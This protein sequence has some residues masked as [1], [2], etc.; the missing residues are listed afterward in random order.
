[1]VILES[2]KEYGAIGGLIAILSLAIKFN[3][4]ELIFSNEIDRIFWTSS[5]R[6]VS[7]LITMMITFVGIFLI[8]F[9]LGTLSI[10][11]PKWANML[12]SILSLILFILYMYLMIL[13]I[14]KK[15]FWFYDHLRKSI[16]GISTS[17]LICSSIAIGNYI[18]ITVG[19]YKDIE[20]FVFT[21][22]IFLSLVGLTYILLMF[23]SVHAIIYRKYIKRIFLIKD[24]E[25][26]IP[27]CKL[28]N[29]LIVIRNTS[30]DEDSFID[31]NDIKDYKMK[32]LKS[33]SK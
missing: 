15:K 12:V 13:L 17:I 18:Y 30:N 20:S 27:M 31:E 26:Y 6:S 22:D 8:V 25:K 9:I 19:N 14:A 33:D 21:N 23:L 29:G 10:V 11:L 4:G 2:L 32:W 16:D 3:V 24:N 28:Q 1:M 5:R 7:R